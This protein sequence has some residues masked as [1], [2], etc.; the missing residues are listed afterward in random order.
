MR[1][2]K[3]LDSERLLKVERTGPDLY[4]ID[5][6]HIIWGVK[7]KEV[8]DALLFGPEPLH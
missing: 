5:R 1:G 6:A 2:E 4:Y 8:L 7:E 3:G